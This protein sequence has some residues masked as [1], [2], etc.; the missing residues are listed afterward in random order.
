MGCST[1]TGMPWLCPN[2]TPSESSCVA[3]HHQHLLRQCSSSSSRS[4]SGCFLQARKPDLVAW[5]DGDALKVSQAPA[6]GKQT[7]EAPGN[8]L[9]PRNS[10]FIDTEAEKDRVRYGKLITREGWP[11]SR[12]QWR[13]PR[14]KRPAAAPP[15]R[16]QSAWRPLEG[17]LLPGPDA[18]ADGELHRCCK[19]AAAPRRVPRRAH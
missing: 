16:T 4:N 18:A 3:L 14:C 2:S 13:L 12:G 8:C 5:F 10:C 1:A 11:H 7:P 17:L 19:A 15:S 6:D 9:V